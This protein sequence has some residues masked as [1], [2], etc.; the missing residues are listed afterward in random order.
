MRLKNFKWRRFFLL[1][2]WMFVFTLIFQII[3]DL[4]AKNAFIN[5]FSWHQLVLR[6]ITAMIIAFFASFLLWGNK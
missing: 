6:G 3:L 1:S 4:I 2:L 5:L